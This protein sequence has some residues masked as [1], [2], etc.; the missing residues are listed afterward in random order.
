MANAKT[1]AQQCGWLEVRC[2]GVIC[3]PLLLSAIDVLQYPPSSQQG[4]KRDLPCYW[5]AFLSFHNTQTLIWRETAHMRICLLSICLC[6]CR[7]ACLRCCATQ[8]LHSTLPDL[9]SDSGQKFIRNR[10]VNCEDTICCGWLCKAR[11]EPSETHDSSG[12]SESINISKYASL[13]RPLRYFA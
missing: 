11:R 8:Q 4:N 2:L 10:K 12:C 1:G 6:A 13:R 9:S 7:S 3:G 5:S